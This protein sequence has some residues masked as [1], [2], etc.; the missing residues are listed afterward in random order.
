MLRYNTE[1]INTYEMK[2]FLIPLKSMASIHCSPTRENRA[3]RFKK[4][5]T[6]G[7]SNGTPYSPSPNTVH[8]PKEAET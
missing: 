3:E 1:G 5:E 8:Q 2:V 4:K 7:M 6:E